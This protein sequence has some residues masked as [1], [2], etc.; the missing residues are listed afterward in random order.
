M[1]APASDAVQ[2]AHL[3]EIRL[4]VESRKNDRAD[5]IR[6]LYNSARGMD[7]HEVVDWS[8]M[9]KFVARCTAWSNRFEVFILLVVLFNIV[10]MFLEADADLQCEACSKPVFEA[11]NGALLAIYTLEAGLALYV[12]QMDFF[13]GAWNLVD[14]IIVV[15]GYVEVILQSMSSGQGLSLVRT[16]KM[17]RILRVARLLKPFPELYKLVAGFMHTLKTMVWGFVLIL[18]LLIIGS[19]ITVQVVESTGNIRNSFELDWCNEAFN[20]VPYMFLLHFQILIAGD[21]WG[22]CVIPATQKSYGLFLLFAI[23]LIVVQ[24]GFTNLILAVIVDASA[25]ARAEDSEEKVKRVKKERENAICEI[26][27]LMERLDTDNS[28][29]ITQEELL[30]GMKSDKQLSHRISALGLDETNMHKLIEVMDAD[31]SGDISYNEFCDTLL[32]LDQQ[33]SRVQTA[34]LMFHVEG[35]RK[36]VQDRF[37]VIEDMLVGSTASGERRKA[38][39]A[40]K[41]MRTRSGLGTIAN[42]GASNVAS[43]EPLKLDE[44]M[45]AALLSADTLNASVIELE[46]SAAMASQSMSPSV[47]SSSAMVPPSREPSWRSKD[48]SLPSIAELQTLAREASEEAAALARKSSFLHTALATKAPVPQGPAAVALAGKFYVDGV[49][50]RRAAE[51]RSITPSECDENGS[52]VPDEI[53]CCKV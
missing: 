25:D 34:F 30:E 42:E 18:V 11:I 53:R 17:C 8:P 22:A 36:L 37:A 16:V 51:T 44:A 7:R 46:K 52:E 5:R 15:L 45:P 50:T 39:K 23:E 21:S 6:R 29:S 20:S 33:D 27:R 48:P 10:V 12:Q 40:W 4:E 24:L 14:C 47:D 32:T 2:N 41:S 19:I 28:G 31:G 9:R 49:T 35:I 26:G 43:C 13:F 1:A 38:L 3:K